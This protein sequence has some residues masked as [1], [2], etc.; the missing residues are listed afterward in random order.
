MGRSKIFI[1]VTHVTF[2]LA[3]DII[4]VIVKYLIHNNNTF[5]NLI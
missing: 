5:C 4:T 2:L 3:N 1:I